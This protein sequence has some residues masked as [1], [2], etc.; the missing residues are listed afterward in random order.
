VLARTLLGCSAEATQA[1]GKVVDRIRE[2]PTNYLEEL[3][4]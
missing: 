3:I 1:Y 2:N 4:G